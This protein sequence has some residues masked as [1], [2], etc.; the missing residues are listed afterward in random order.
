MLLGNAWVF[1]P[2]TQKVAFV[3][4]GSDL[5]QDVTSSSNSGNQHTA[6][7]IS[8]DVLHSR[9]SCHKII[10]AAKNASGNYAACVHYKRQ[11]NSLPPHPLLSPASSW[12]PGECEAPSCSHHSANRVLSSDVLSAATNSVPCLALLVMREGRGENV[13]HGRR[14][15]P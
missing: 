12:E 5:K 6:H 4:Y 14:E 10:I 7:N 8:W 11:P 13:F 3:S 9:G 1:L 15:G 2:A